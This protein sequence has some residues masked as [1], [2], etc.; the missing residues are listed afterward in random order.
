MHIT[1]RWDRVRDRI[2]RSTPT[3]AQ[4]RKLFAMHVIRSTGFEIFL[5]RF[6]SLFL[7]FSRLALCF[8]CS[9]PFHGLTMPAAICVD[10]LIA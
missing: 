1:R 9:Q 7:R 4:L 8:A 3:L 5:L 10:N 6:T 2:A